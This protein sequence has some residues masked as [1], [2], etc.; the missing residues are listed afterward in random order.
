MQNS[1]IDRGPCKRNCPCLHWCLGWPPN[2]APNELILK[3]FYPRTWYV[4]PMACPKTSWLWLDR[5]GHLWRHVG[6]GKPSTQQ[7]P[8][9]CNACA[10]RFGF[11][12]TANTSQRL[13]KCVPA[14]EIQISRSLS[15]TGPELGVPLVNYHKLSRNQSPLRHKYVV[16]LIG[17][18]GHQGRRT[19]RVRDMPAISR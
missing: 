13:P 19:G 16:H 2:T 4:C 7:D 3:A 15:T 11:R 6:P 9:G 8:K 10:F 14:S 12:V 17:V 1:G 5:S 18:G